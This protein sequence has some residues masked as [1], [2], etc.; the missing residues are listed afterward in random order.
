MAFVP[1][2]FVATIRSAYFGALAM[3][4]VEFFVR[5]KIKLLRRYARESYESL[6]SVP[7][8]HSS[9]RNFSVL[10]ACE[11]GM[12]LFQSNTEIRWCQAT[13]DRPLRHTEE[14]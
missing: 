11:L 5:E 14:T 3:S 12:A 8:L 7:N 4:P 1:L 9:R 10:A 2:R 13:T 6:T